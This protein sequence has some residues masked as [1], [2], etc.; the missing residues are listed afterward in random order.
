MAAPSTTQVFGFGRLIVNP[1]TDVAAS[2]YGGTVLGTPGGVA[3]RPRRRSDPHVR[4]DLG[5]QVADVYYRG[6]DCDVV[7]VMKGWDSDALTRIYGGSS[8]LVHLDGTADAWLGDTSFG[9]LYAPDR[10]ASPGFYIPRAIAMHERL[11][12]PFS[13]YLPL[14]HAVRF[15]ALPPATG[16][17]VRMGT[18]AQMSSEWIP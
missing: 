7:A 16:D 11:E 9:L 10:E 17:L 15:L 3:V 12:I 18:V 1:T 4:E 2:A 14:A 6:E 5:G 13:G 8:G